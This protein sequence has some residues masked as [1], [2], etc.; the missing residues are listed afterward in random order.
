MNIC[1]DS[2][3]VEK[4]DIFFCIKGTVT[5]GHRF[6]EMA[7]KKGAS[8]I[9]YEDELENPYNEGTVYIKVSDTVK[10]LN[11]AC[12]SFYGKPS[13]NMTVFGITGTNGKTTTSNIISQVYSKKEL[14]GYIGTVNLKL[15]N[16]TREPGL[17]TPDTLTMHQ[18]LSQMKK[19]GAKAVALEVSAHGLTQGR[20][21]AI[22]FDYAIFSNFTH[23]HLD[24]YG[25]MENYFNAKKKLFKMLKKD[26]TAILNK[27]ISVYDE[28]LNSCSC[29]TVSYGIDT[30]SDYM[31]ENIEYFTDHTEFTLRHHNESIKVSTNLIARY[32][33]YN[34]L[35]AAAALH[36]AGITFKEIASGFRYINQIPGRLEKIDRGQNFNA[37]VDYAHTPDGYEQLLSFIKNKLA[38]ESRL[39]TVCGAPGGRD[40]SKRKDLGKIASKYSDKLIVT[41][42]DPRGENPDEIISQLISG[43]EK[44]NFV[45]IPERKDAIKEAV[46]IARK[47]DFVL[48]LGKGVENFMHTEHGKVPYEGDNNVLADAI[49]AILN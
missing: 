22:D 35:S 23:D 44:N 38:K 18:I 30:I 25:T 17:T 3:K 27:D 16:N 43:I 47:N 4:G 46:S 34:L 42:Y 24:Y 36:E 13:H 10:A 28:L 41:I 26:A 45:A 11:E 15:G 7:A 31:A 32:N 1:T 33:V 37:Y 5:D 8:V 19:D 29:K 48:V 9:V 12:S 20:V 40:H 2:R 49:D 21:D 14:C 6:A 39:I